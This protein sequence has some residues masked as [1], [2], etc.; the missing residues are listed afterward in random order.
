MYL[1]TAVSSGCYFFRLLQAV[2]FRVLFL[3]AAIS[4]DCFRVSASGCCFFRLLQGVC[5]ML[6]LLQAGGVCVGHTALIDV[7]AKIV[8]GS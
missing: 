5:F 3:Q 4:S 8:K 6:L 7:D 2:C 1:Q